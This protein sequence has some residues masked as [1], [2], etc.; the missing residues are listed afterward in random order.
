MPFLFFNYLT[1]VKK[2]AS[3]EQPLLFMYTLNM[4]KI[5]SHTLQQCFNPADLFCNRLRVF[6]GNCLS[7]HSTG[8]LQFL[9]LHT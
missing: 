6:P 5:F 2:A 1:N 7:R 8:F 3:F 9:D 4:L